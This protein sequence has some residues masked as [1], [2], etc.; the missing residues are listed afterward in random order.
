MENN[1][2]P[3][4]KLLKKSEA[5]FRLKKLSQTGWSQKTQY[6]IKY[7]KWYLISPSGNW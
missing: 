3:N 2:K 1:S 5:T 6:Y 7:V 4:I